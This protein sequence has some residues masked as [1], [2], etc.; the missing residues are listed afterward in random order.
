MAS[1]AA[2]HIVANGYVNASNV[3]LVTFGQPRT[4]DHDY[5]NAINGQ[6]AKDLCVAVDYY[7]RYRCTTIGITSTQKSVRTA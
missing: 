3:K 5:A 1:L 6:P 7:T 2:S 4:G